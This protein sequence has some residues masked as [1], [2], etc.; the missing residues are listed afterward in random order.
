MASNNLR[1]T[2][3]LICLLVL[4]PLC[5]ASANPRWNPNLTPIKL[6][7]KNANEVLIDNFRWGSTFDGRN[8][9]AIYG[10][11]RIR[12]SEVDKVY[13][14]SEDFPPKAVAAHVSLAFTFKSM[15]G[16]TSP[17][18]SKSDFGLVI[19]V[20]NRL[21]ENET[22]TSF[23]KAFFPA[24]SKD[25]WP[26]VFEVGTLTD[27]AQNS[28]TI[29]RQ[30]IKMFPLRLKQDQVES[31]LRAGIQQSLVDRSRDYYHVLGNNC[32]VWAY[33]ILMQG[34]GDQFFKDFWVLPNKVVS[35]NVSL[36]KFSPGY[37]SKKGLNAGERV[38]LDANQRVVKIPTAM[39]IKT[40]DL[41][42]LPGYQRAPSNLVPLVLQLENY[43]QLRNAEIDLA[44]LNELLSP[45]GEDF[46]R[47]L[48]ARQKVTDEINDSI[49]TIVRLVRKAPEESLKFYVQGL[50]QHK[51]TRDNRYAPLNKALFLV[52]QF[53]MNHA[54]NRDK[55]D[56]LADLKSFESFPRK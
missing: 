24:F 23:T 19:S 36:P 29:F 37:L 55:A 34:L 21:R 14:C 7:S 50:K 43:V 27:R 38:V 12:F 52:V 13:L 16:V 22:P 33:R 40:I 42:K 8:F 53:E 35:H 17:D 18:G 41:T 48:K 44:R 32:V 25:P 30:T 6:V 26:L 51:L 45:A 39:G 1:L 28:L 49:D 4:L 3:L 11:A 47:V 10:R 15:N 56:Y 5:M 20:T 54:N 9:Q 46:F 2:A 31:I